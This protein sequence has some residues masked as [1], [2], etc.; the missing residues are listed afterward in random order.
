[1]RIG[2]VQTEGYPF[3][4]LEWV[5]YPMIAVN[6]LEY[7]PKVLYEYLLSR[8]GQSV[9]QEAHCRTMK[10][11]CIIVEKMVDYF[12]KYKDIIPVENRRVLK[13]IVLSNVT[14]IYFHFL[15]NWPKLLDDSILIDYDEE[16]NRISPELY[17]TAGLRVERRKFMSFRFIEEWRKKKS[18][19]T[20]V[21]YFFDIGVFV[22]RLI[23]NL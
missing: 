17:E 10:E 1:V 23:G 22:G 19:N 8:E 3:T 20:I 12:E 13:E 15:I 6:T 11:D 16:L 21:Y 2:Y 7:F 5:S 18:R 4:D 9:S 14:R